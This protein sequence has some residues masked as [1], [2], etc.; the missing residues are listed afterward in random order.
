[1][2]NDTPQINNESVYKR[3]IE[4]GKCSFNLLKRFLE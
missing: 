2:P 4:R 3:K 1:M